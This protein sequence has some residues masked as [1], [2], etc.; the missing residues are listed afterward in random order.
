[1]RIFEPFFTTKEA[2]KGTGLGLATVYGIVQQSGGAIQVESEP[3]QGAVFRVYLPRVDEPSAV[4]AQ[5]AEAAPV[6]G[7]RETV[8]VVEDEEAVRKLE[9]ESLAAQGYRVR[10]AA[11][12][13]EALA[14]AERMP[15]RIDL[16]V[17]DVVMPGRSGREL[18]EELSRR[19]PGLRVLFVSGYVDDEFPD[20]GQ[21]GSEVWFLPKPF[22]PRVLA[23]KVREVLD[24]ERPA[25]AA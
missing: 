5:D 7:G 6:A 11:D 22:T 20:A 14:L 13:Q 18:A 17:T 1:V 12:A 19:R 9:A 21:A 25:Q 10:V 4:R 2:G 8:L 24:A 16:L 23:N 15:E 3:G